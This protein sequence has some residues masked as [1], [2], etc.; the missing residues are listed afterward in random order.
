MKSVTSF[1]FEEIEG[2][3]FGYSPVGK[4]NL[5]V[6]IYYID[7][8]LIDTGQRLMQ[9][10]IIETL[11]ELPI[12]QIFATHHHEDHTGNLAALQQRFSCPVYAAPP[13]CELMKH[14]PNLS[15]AQKMVW[16][17]R[18]A[19]TTIKPIENKIATEN[20]S[21]N[22]I[23]IPGHASDMV[24]LYEPNR[25]WL[26]SADLFI[27]SY[28]GYY[29]NNESMAAQINSIE[30]ILKLD[31]DVMLC[32]HKPIFENGK[33]KLKKKLDFLKNFYGQVAELHQKGLLPNQIFKRLKLKEDWFIRLLSGG[34]LSKLNM[35]KSVIRDIEEGKSVN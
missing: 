15:F 30:S 26:F 25:K 13:C 4:P 28:I 11:S 16:G 32:A 27:N 8:L 5:L 7:G 21:F 24:A 12:Q 1:K 22:I 23:P 18:E 33:G 34:S 6:N 20:F 2:F 17:N 31:F 19:Y 9:K 3:R 14:P 10:E 35:V 29:L